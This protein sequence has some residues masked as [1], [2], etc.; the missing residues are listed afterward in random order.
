V[1]P[2]DVN[3]SREQ[4]EDSIRGTIAHELTLP[5]KNATILG[6]RTG[7][8]LIHARIPG[9]ERHA[10]GENVWLT[11]RRYHVFDKKSGSRLRSYPET[12]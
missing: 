12:A 5:M 10:I 1:R 4:R 3:V 7:N 11:F 8:Q 9:D 2:E 6:I